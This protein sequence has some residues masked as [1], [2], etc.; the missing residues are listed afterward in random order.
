MNGLPTI[1]K[2]ALAVAQHVHD[3]GYDAVIVSGGSNQL[4]RSLLALAW[5][6]LYPGER[7]PHEFVLDWRANALLYKWHG[8]AAYPADFEAWMHQGMPELEAAKEQKL[9]FVDDFIRQGEKYRGVTVALEML[10][11]HHTSFAFFGAQEDSEVGND[12]FIGA[13]SSELVSELIELGEHIR[14]RPGKMEQ[15]RDELAGEVRHYRREAV[16]ELRQV[17]QE[18]RKSRR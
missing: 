9:C 2:A 6:A 8:A 7:V 11:F 16:S 5:S 3:G 14:D 10:G 12:A 17:G 15:V 1:A 4:S 13:R 18:I